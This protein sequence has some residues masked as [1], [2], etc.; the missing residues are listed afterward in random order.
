VV[1]FGSTADIAGSLLE[2]NKRGYGYT[3]SVEPIAEWEY[4]V[5]G[6]VSGAIELDAE[7][8]TDEEFVIDEVFALVDELVVPFGGECTECRLTDREAF[9]T[10]TQGRG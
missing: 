7:D 10:G 2:M 1:N 3:N 8:S 9:R 4:V 5:S 6:T